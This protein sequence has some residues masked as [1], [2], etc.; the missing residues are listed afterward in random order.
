M[1]F[2]SIAQRGQEVHDVCAGVEVVAL[3]LLEDAGVEV[4]GV[5]RV[6][7]GVVGGLEGGVGAGVQVVEEGG[8]AHADFEGVG[9]GVLVGILGMV[10]VGG[11]EAWWKE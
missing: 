2:R 1:R 6:A 9:H 5:G 10:E 8:E 3:E 11:E 7:E 4:F